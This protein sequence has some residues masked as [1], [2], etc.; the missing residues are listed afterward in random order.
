MRNKR[1]VDGE[2]PQALDLTLR[3]QRPIKGIARYRVGLDGRERM[4]F[5]DRDDPDAGHPA[6]QSRTLRSVK[7]GAP[8][9]GRNFH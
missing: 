7:P 6:S 8:V 4:A 9:A 5:I 2:E 1:A 3:E